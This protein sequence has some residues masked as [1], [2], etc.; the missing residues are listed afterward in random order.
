MATINGS[1]SSSAW[2]YKLEVSESNVNI[3]NN[4]SVV[5]VKAYLGRASSQSYLGGAWS[6]SI[7]VSGSTQSMSGT[8]SYPT[9]INGGSWLQLAT[10]T[11]TVT[12]NNDG[13]KVASISSSFSSSDF[14]PSSAS[15]S[16]NVTLTTIPRSS[17][18]TAT[19]VYIGETSQLTVT[20][21][22]NSF[23]HT[24]YYSFGN[25]NG[26]ILADGSTTS[27]ATKINATSIGFPIPSTWFEQIPNAKQGTCTLTITTYNGN[28]QISS[29]KTS[30]FVA[31]VDQTTSSPIVTSSV[32]DTNA[33]TLALTNN[34]NI[35]IK[36]FSI[37]EVTWSATSQN[38]ST[39]T[40]VAINGTT[41]TTSPYSFTLNESAINVVAT[42]SRE[43]S[44][45]SN[46]SF[47]L[48]DYNAP[49]L[50]MSLKRVS[51]TSG[52]ANLL[53]SG[54][55]FNDGFGNVQNSLTISWKYKK[56]TDSTWIN[57]GTL[58]LNTDYKI[59]NNTFY[60]GI[61]TSAEE[62][63]IGGNLDY[64][65]AW[66]IMIYI[67]DELS[68]FNTYQ[69]ITQGIPIIN[70]GEDF[71]NV[72][73]D[74]NQFGSPI[75]DSG[76]NANGNYVKFL[77][78]TMICTKQKQ[79]TVKINKAWGSLYE[80][81]SAINFGDYAETFTAIPIVVALCIGR[82][83]I[84]EGLQNQSTTSYGSTWLMRPVAD[85]TDNDYVIN[86]I[87]IGKWK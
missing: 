50:T 40:N 53:F 30:S 1:T 31:R 15:A 7:T 62:I 2:T 43:F 79:A 12:H 80:T 70:W 8:I 17:T 5:T 6:G 49:L 10:K 73:G 71:F 23:T 22:S 44:T 11:F 85:T 38:S 52:Y 64:N 33:T 75:V 34:S 77:D 76:S 20:R 21:Y 18:I 66:D 82:T 13:S 45:T 51:P 68:S 28:T 57:G 78:G 83:A 29:A 16:G 61:G 81:Q 67:E 74:I 24:I 32:E 41:V 60:S 55:W 39:I 54:T 4:T 47:I 3:N 58:V 59:S 36:G 35:L 46:P 63:E 86:L 25:L 27:T 72:N 87:A 26:Y 48:K 56:T 14:T 37:P 69:T 42:D 65:Y 84:L 9:Y 19:S